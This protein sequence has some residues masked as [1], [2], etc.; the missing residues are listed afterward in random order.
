MARVFCLA[1]PEHQPKGRS[2]RRRRSKQFAGAG[3][4]ALGARTPPPDARSE[5]SNETLE[6]ARGVSPS[7][8]KT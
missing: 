7:T 8:A 3:G 1:W 2:F 5:G 4:A 6:V